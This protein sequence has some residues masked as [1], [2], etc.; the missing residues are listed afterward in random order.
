MNAPPESSPH[1]SGNH[2]ATVP[3]EAAEAVQRGL[4]SILAWV[5]R[6]PDAI[7]RGE[8]ERWEHELLL[9]GWDAGGRLPLA[10]LARE[11]AQ[12]AGPQRERLAWACLCVTEWAL[13]A[14]AVST[15]L[16]YAEAAAR[17]WPEQGRYAWTAG[18]LLHAYGWNAAGDEWLRQAARVTEKAGDWEGQA[19][20]L[21]ALHSP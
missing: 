5:D 15:G 4:R 11:L 2:S 9:G 19:R 14:G 21:A 6:G 16:A 8:M 10:V 13:E 17:A 7:A 12:P 20:S 18:R 3:T 1:P